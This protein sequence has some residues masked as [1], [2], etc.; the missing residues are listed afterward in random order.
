[1]NE[2]TWDWLLVFVPGIVSAF[3]VGFYV[4]RDCAA[5]PTVDNRQFPAPIVA[6]WVPETPTPAPLPAGRAAYSGLAIVPVGGPVALGALAAGLGA[7]VPVVAHALTEGEMIAVL[8]EAGWPDELLPEALSVS[9]CESARR[10]P[11]TGNYYWRPDAVGDGGEDVAVE[12]VLG[13]GVVALKEEKREGVV[14]RA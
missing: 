8:R 13:D 12:G 6:G 10:D 3:A 1:M 14:V 2:R 4:G 9:R 11:A 5:Q 7:V